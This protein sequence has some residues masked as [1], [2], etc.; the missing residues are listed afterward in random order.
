MKK[1]NF[2]GF[3]GSKVVLFESKATTFVRKKKNV[4]RNILRYKKINKLFSCPRILNIGK[5]FYDMEYLNG[6]SIEQYLEVNSIENLSKFIF[7]TLQILKKKNYGQKDYSE[8]YINF[9][10]QIDLKKDFG[11]D[12]DNF[13]SKL[14]KVLP[15]TEYHGDFTLENIIYSKNKFFL[16]DWSEGLFDSYVFDYVKLR[17]DV[18]CGWFVRRNNNLNIF[19]KLNKLDGILKKKLK[20]YDNNYILILMLLRVFRYT[21]KFNLEYY[22]IK[23]KIKSLWKL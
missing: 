5:D 12:K 2:I 1:K 16:I 11:I 20:Y 3:S 4:Q 18:L 17:Q 6:L 10:N 19:S 23:N 9:L 14:P 21:K 22:F 8:I 7:K 13:L 15:K